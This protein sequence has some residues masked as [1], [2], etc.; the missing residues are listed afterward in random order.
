MNHKT[1][2]S[3]SRPDKQAQ[4]L[5]E[6][7]PLYRGFWGDVS[8]G[9]RYCP[10]CDKIVCLV[11]GGIH[12]WNFTSDNPDPDNLARGRDLARNSINLNQAG[13]AL[14]LPPGEPK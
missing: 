5:G 12:P 4:C 8:W 13:A 9:V 2:L 14:P 1:A 10:G 6:L 11:E 3:S 7:I